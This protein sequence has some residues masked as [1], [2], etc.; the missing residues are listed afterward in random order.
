M[1][2]QKRNHI[3]PAHIISLFLS[4]S[5]KT[6]DNKGMEKAYYTQ[7]VDGSDGSFIK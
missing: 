4:L 6:E 7:E 5:V 2:H 1:N 3:P